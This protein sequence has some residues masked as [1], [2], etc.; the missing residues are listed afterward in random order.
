[1][2]LPELVVAFKDVIGRIDSKLLAVQ[3]N[4]PSVTWECWGSI[5]GPI[6]QPAL[7]VLGVS[8]TVEKPVVVNGEIVIRDYGL[9]LV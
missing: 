4:S 3:I 2:S 8:S 5:I 9:G 6:N 1:M 7:S